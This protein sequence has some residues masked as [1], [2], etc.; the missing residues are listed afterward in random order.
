MLDRLG[1]A[2]SNSAV[3]DISQSLAPYMRDYFRRDPRFQGRLGV[4]SSYDDYISIAVGAVHTQTTAPRLKLPRV[5]LT[6]LTN[7]PPPDVLEQLLTNLIALVPQ[8]HV[9]FFDADIN[10]RVP[11]E[12]FFA[13]PN[14]ETLHLSN[15]LLSERFLQ[16]DPAGPNANTKLFPSLPGRC[17]LP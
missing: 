3:Q 14:I 12:P 10:A 2:V 9:V 11:E 8:D 4:S 6:V 5:L 7:Q 13:M 17:R 15:M 1:L 16:P